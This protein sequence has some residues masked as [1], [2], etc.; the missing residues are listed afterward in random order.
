MQIP[1]S[2]LKAIEQY[3][4]GTATPDQ[5]QLVYNWYRSFD[6]TQ[7]EIP[8]SIIELKVKVGQR[9][10]TRLEETI[11]EKENQAEEP[12]PVVSRR[13]QW[14]RVAVAAVLLLAT[15]IFLLREFA[16]KKTDTP[17]AVIPV[18]HDVQPGGLKAI[19]TLANG[20]QII[21]DSASNGTL[22]QQGNA[23]VIKTANGQVLYD[24]AV[25]TANAGEVL[26]NTM[27]TPRGGLYKLTLSD[28]TE[29]WLNATSSIRY[30]TVFRGNSRTVEITGEVFF[31][32]TKNKNMPFR[33]MIGGEEKNSIEVLGTR[34]NV[35]AYDD[36]VL[37]KT[38]LL[39][40][41]VKLVSSTGNNASLQPGQQAQV[42][43]V[44]QI[45][46]KNDADMD[47]ATAWING[48]FQFKDTDIK[49]LMRQ[50]ARW[51]D[52]N[53]VYYGGNVPSLLIT[54][55]AP[56]NISLASMLKILELSDVKYRID[57]KTLTVFN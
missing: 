35:M 57:G 23:R 22:T 12:V 46:V 51:Y 17:V 41:A 10:W 44:G 28:G 54:G 18:T 33:V 38:S 30:P 29:V 16:A 45:Q 15:G 53:V 20:K 4:A 52:I 24:A 42:D 50:L 3:L 21:L 1:D 25:A 34:F 56:R 47:E 2:L 6:D 7:V 48:L 32:V 14:W 37:L 11:S 36:E 39:E 5:Q 9:I 40:G 19:L 49:S 31:K 43:E 55:K 26:Y 27:S 8:V 13:S